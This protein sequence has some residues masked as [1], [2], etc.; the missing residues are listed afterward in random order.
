M[1]SIKYCKVINEH[2]TVIKT[3]I[4]YLPALETNLPIENGIKIEKKT[5]R[6]NIFLP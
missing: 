4:N 3:I 5:G 2:F 6:N 1:T